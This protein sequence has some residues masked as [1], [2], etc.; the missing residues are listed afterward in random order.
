MK[1]LNGG[2]LFVALFFAFTDFII[3]QPFIYTCGKDTIYI[4]KVPLSPIYQINLQN[5]KK[6]IVDKCQGEMLLD[7]TDTW[8]FDLYSYNHTM[9]ASVKKLG[10]NQESKG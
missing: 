7:N 4:E 1:Y 5:G 6:M 2:I 3:A 10:I 8:L 9:D